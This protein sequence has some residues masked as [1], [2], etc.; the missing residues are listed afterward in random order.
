[1][2]AEAKRWQCHRQLIADALVARGV[3][4]CHIMS[5]HDAH[6]TRSPRLPAW[7]AA[8]CAIPRSREGKWWVHRLGSC[9][10]GSLR[11]RSAAAATAVQR[12]CL[13]EIFHR[14]SGRGVQ[15][16][17]EKV[18]LSPI[19]PFL[20]CAPRKPSPTIEFWAL[21]PRPQRS[22][23]D[24]KRGAVRGAY[25]PQLWERPEVSRE[26]AADARRA[27]GRFTGRDLRGR[28][29]G[30]AGSLVR[31]VRDGLALR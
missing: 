4:V 15:K 17:L 27:L 1:M 14:I 24:D 12:G 22:T 7:R 13:D 2:C 3:A 31:R 23:V 20:H 30:C 21:G 28:P 10:H 8:A 5:G 18:S 9:T 6:V 26:D 25:L 19:G 11:A 29:A 16:R